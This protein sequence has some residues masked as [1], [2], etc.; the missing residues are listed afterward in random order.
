MISKLHEALQ[1]K[2][3]VASLLPVSELQCQLVQFQETVSS[4]ET[5]MQ[6]RTAGTHSR[7]TEL[8]LAMQD[9]AGIA[10]VREIEATGLLNARGIEKLGA[11]VSESA[12]GIVGSVVSVDVGGDPIVLLDDD[13][14]PEKMSW[15]VDELDDVFDVI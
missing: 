11:I 1:E 3:S 15:L 7:L 8:Q 9:N 2:A 4:F 10:L 14:A 13:A 12:T 5:A 6:V